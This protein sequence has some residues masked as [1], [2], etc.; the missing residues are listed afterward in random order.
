MHFKNIAGTALSGLCIIMLCS[1]LS[2]NA[3]IRVD[4]LG[5]FVASTPCSEG[6]SPVPG[7]S[8]DTCEFI[9]WKLALYYDSSTKTPLNYT[10]DCVYGISQPGTNGFKGGGTKLKRE[11][12]WTITKGI[13]NDTNALVYQL[14]PDKPK[15][16]IAF[17]K[18]N[19]QLLHLLDNKK[20]LMIGNAAWSY[21]LN[22]IQPTN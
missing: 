18:M 17:W 22:K 19:E 13:N 9:K 3:Q 1:C 20:Q 12:N 2:T 21:T 15:E 14:D 7:M 6:S 8:G 4:L 5:I 16:S 11:G 10:L